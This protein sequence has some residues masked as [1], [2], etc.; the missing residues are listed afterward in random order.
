[1]SAED[2]RFAGVARLY[3]IEG[4]ER[5]RAAHVAIV[6][7]GESDIGK[8]PGMTGLGLNAPAAKRA[9]ILRATVAWW[10]NIWGSGSCC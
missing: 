1:M 4:L 6:G 5:L 10:W 8:V 3:G 7:V 2:P 9:T